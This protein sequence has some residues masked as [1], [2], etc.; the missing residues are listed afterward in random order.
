ME[1]SGASVNLFCSHH[2]RINCTISPC[3]FPATGDAFG[4]LQRLTEGLLQYPCEELGSDV[5]KVLS[6]MQSGLSF[7]NGDPFLR[8]DRAG[9]EFPDDPLDGHTGLRVPCEDCMLNW[10]SAAPAGQQRGMEIDGCDP[11]PRKDLIGEN[12]SVGDDD[13][14]IRMWDRGLGTPGK[15]GIDILRLPNG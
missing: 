14:A 2:L 8:E 5:R 13:Q 1:R 6:E 15:I 4:E 7:F 11:R 12:L 9:I 3:E 10:R